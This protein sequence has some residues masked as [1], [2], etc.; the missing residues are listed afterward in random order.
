MA[1]GKLD[2]I[3]EIAHDLAEFSSGFQSHK[4]YAIHMVSSVQ[5]LFTLI[6]RG[7]RIIKIRQAAR[8]LSNFF[9][10]SFLFFPVASIKGSCWDV[11]YQF[12]LRFLTE[13]ILNSWFLPPRAA[14]QT[15][16]HSSSLMQTFLSTFAYEV[17]QTLQ[18][19]TIGGVESL[20]PWSFS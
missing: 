14:S 11:F 9:F 17:K 1:E 12:A 7:K 19:N 6:E 2:K 20:L 13:V 15:S 18:S 3:Q 4:V 10:F 16:R 5:V 8:A